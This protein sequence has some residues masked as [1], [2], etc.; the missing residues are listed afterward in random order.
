M[1]RWI[2][3]LLS[4]VVCLQIGGCLLSGSYSNDGFAAFGSGP[5]Y[6]GRAAVLPAIPPYGGSPLIQSMPTGGFFGGSGFS[7]SGGGFGGG[8]SAIGAQQGSI[9]LTGP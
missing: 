5:S 4:F 2:R 9:N 8:F 3:P 7:V 1:G 6:G